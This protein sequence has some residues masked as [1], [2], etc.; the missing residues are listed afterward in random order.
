MAEFCP[1]CGLPVETDGDES[2]LCETCGW[3]GDNSETAKVPPPSDVFNPVLAAVQALFLYRDVCRHEL[4][5]EQ[6]FDA[7]NATEAD[8]RKVKV[9]ARNCLHSL[10]QLFMAIRHPHQAP[11]T[12]LEK[13]DSG[14]VPW[15]EEW[16]DFHY[17]ACKEPCDALVGPCAC[18]AWHT[19]EEIWV[20]ETLARHNTVIK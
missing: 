10:V 16:T 8:L 12:V 2:R 14:I 1:Q 17:N 19:E 6:V 3:F 5:A 13:G 20:R 9:E 4:V 7:G 18:G 15:P 11:P